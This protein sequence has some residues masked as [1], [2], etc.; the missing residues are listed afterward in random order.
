MLLAAIYDGR[1]FGEIIRDLGLTSNQI[2][3]SLNR[4]GMVDRAGGSLM[5]TR[6]DDLKHGTNAA[7][8]AR[9]VCRGCREHQRVR[10]AKTAASSSH[11]VSYRDS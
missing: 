11:S 5:A 2:W 8:V 9:C 7:Y 1:P 4:R 3:G 6:R 10:M